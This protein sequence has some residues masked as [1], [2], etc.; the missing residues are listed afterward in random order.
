[1]TVADLRHTGMHERSVSLQSPSALVTPSPST[2]SG[3]ACE[4]D[5]FVQEVAGAVAGLLQV[6]ELALV[7]FIF[8]GPQ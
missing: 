3:S 6:A 5:A 2:W 1:M 4:V 7:E 8:E